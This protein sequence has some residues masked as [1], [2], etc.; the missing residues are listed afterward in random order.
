MKPQGGQVVAL[1]LPEQG[2][3]RVS[4][5]DEDA[6]EAAAGPEGDLTV[7]VIGTQGVKGQSKPPQG[8]PVA[9]QAAAG[10]GQAG[11]ALM[12]PQRQAY[13]MPANPVVRPESQYWLDATSAMRN[14]QPVSLGAEAPT[15]SHNLNP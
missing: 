5:E 3:K 7:G 1:P 14:N 11:V 8:Q 13:Q 12:E 10:E 9:G 4:P 15:N 6:A 2:A